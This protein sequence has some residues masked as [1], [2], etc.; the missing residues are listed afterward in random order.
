MCTNIRTKQADIEALTS[1]QCK[2]GGGGLSFICRCSWPLI[3]FVADFLQVWG[4]AI[5]PKDTSAQRQLVSNSLLAALFD[6]FNMFRRCVVSLVSSSANMHHKTPF[7]FFFFSSLHSWCC[8]TIVWKS[9]LLRAKDI[10]KA[11]VLA[12]SPPES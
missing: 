5:M 12:P 4:V 6:P 7:F 11:G 10:V 2:N 3:P 9:K 8:H 1:T